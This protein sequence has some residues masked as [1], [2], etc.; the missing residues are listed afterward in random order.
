[1]HKT[2]FV[3]LLMVWSFHSTQAQ[4]EDPPLELSEEQLLEDL[5]FIAK[6]LEYFSSYQGLNGYSYRDDLQAYFTAQSSTLTPTDI[7]KLGLFLTETIGKI[8]DR[9]AYVRG[10]MDDEHK[11]LPFTAAPYDEKVLALQYDQSLKKFHP[12]SDEFPYLKAINHIAIEDFQKQIIPEEIKA[13]PQAYYT[14]YVEMLKYI[15]RNHRLLQRPLPDPCSFTFTNFEKDTTVVLNLANDPKL[16]PIWKEKFDAFAHSAEELNDSTIAQNYF[17]LDS[18]GIAH[19]YIP[20][21]LNEKKTPQFFKTLHA[22]MQQIQ[23]SKALILDV[24]SNS[25][26]RRHLILELAKYIVHPDSIHVVNVAHHRSEGRISARTIRSLNRRSLYAMNTFDK[27]EQ[28]AI[29]HFLETFKPMYKL[30]EKRFSEPYFTLFNGAKLSLGAYHYNKPVYL[31]TNERSFSAASVFAATFKGLPNVHLVGT[32]TD[33][34]SGNSEKY[35]LP[36]SKIRVKLSTMVSFQ[37]DGQLL[38]GYGTKPDIEISRSLQQVLWEEDNQL[39][40]L[41]EMILSNKQ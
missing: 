2:T 16:H 39:Q 24:R 4:T 35:Y 37:K 19:I 41:K 36:H 11:F 22:F 25:G 40:Q 15:E 9:H 13:P 28:Q 1:M 23:S 17:H 33:G 32:T 29:R 6:K 5:E 38:D 7:S 8:G 30:S 10:Y 21:M 18:N 20:E 34:S 31:I 3:L 14:R 27:Q 12:I 26:G